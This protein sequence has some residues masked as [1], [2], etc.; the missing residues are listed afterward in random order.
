M[1]N[2][3]EFDSPNFDDKAENEQMIAQLKPELNI[4]SNQSWSSPRRTLQITAIILIVSFLAHMNV[5][6]PNWNFF[7]YM[8]GAIA[9]AIASLV[10]SS[11]IV[12]LRLLFS[13]FRLNSNKG[14]SYDF[15]TALAI[16]MIITS[17]ILLV[18]QYRAA[19]KRATD[20]IDFERMQKTHESNKEYFDYP[21]T[22]HN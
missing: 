15:L 7:D 11:L 8:G 17:P 20:I 4:P 10:I 1:K 2:Q 21:R 14:A 18:N 3:H 6:H 13:D 19:E 16:P 5:G 22:N 12:G 9:T